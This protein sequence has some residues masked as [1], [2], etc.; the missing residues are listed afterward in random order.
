M[1]AYPPLTRHRGARGLPGG[2][3]GS[4]QQD[5]IAA[6]QVVDRQALAA[7]LDLDMRRARARRSGRLMRI[8]EEIAARVL[9]RQ[10]GR[11]GVSVAEDDEFVRHDGFGWRQAHVEILEPGREPREGLRQRARRDRAP[12]R[13]I[14]VEQPRIRGT[15]HDR[16]EL[17]REVVRVV[18]AGVAPKS[19]GGRHDVR[20]VTDQEH[21]A[22]AEPISD[23]TGDLPAPGVHEIDLHIGLAC[24]P[25]DELAAALRRVVFRPLPARG[26]VLDGQEPAAF[27]PGDERAVQVRHEAGCEWTALQ[28]RRQVRVEDD[29]HPV[30][31]LA[32]TAAQDAQRFARRAVRAIRRY[33]ISRP[34]RVPGPGRPVFQPRRHALLVLLER[35]QLRVEADVRAEPLRV[36]AQ[37]RLQSI[38]IARR[39]RRRREVVGRGPRGRHPLN[40]GIREVLHARDAA[41]LLVAGA[42]RADVVL[43]SRPPVNLHRARRDAAELVLHG[44]GG[45]AFDDDGAD[46]LT[47][48]QERRREAGQ[49]A[50]HDEHGDVGLLAPVH[51]L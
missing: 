11:G 14:R 10:D 44:G 13:V 47:A 51:L 6:E 4:S 29:V 34:H 28:L 12:F 7:A 2:P 16:R 15:R 33:E 30:L 3:T 32:R 38:L 37:D 21:P 36:R 41:G 26:N 1:A 42:V 40:V 22:L 45:V 31:Q 35:R 43:H 50:A 24:S 48:E 9:L 49:A 25:A 20:G 8:L 46:A 19:A 27:I 39:G 5:E 17:P 23:L 18:D